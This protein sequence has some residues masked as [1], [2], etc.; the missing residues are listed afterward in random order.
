MDQHYEPGSYNEVI[1]TYNTNNCFSYLCNALN[2][3]FVYCRGLAIN[4]TSDL[5][6][7]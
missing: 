7:Q 2:S 3:E 4:N 1:F 6:I 5:E